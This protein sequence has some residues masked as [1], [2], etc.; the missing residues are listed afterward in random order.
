MIISRRF[1]ILV[2]FWYSNLEC[3]IAFKVVNFTNSKM[4]AL[5]IMI[6]FEKL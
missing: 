4:W 6:V 5:V 1:R 3:K 2:G